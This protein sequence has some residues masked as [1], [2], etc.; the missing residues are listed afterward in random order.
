VLI[1]LNTSTARFARSR[2]SPAS[3]FLAA[4]IGAFEPSLRYAKIT[5]A[6]LRR[7]GVGKRTREHAEAVGPKLKFG[8]SNFQPGV[9]AAAEKVVKTPRMAAS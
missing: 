5:P 3:N 2:Q 7:G 4:R 6:A 1:H 8:L 9:S